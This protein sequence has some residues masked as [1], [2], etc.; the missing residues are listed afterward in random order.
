[1]MKKNE[2]SQSMRKTS[3]FLFNVSQHVKLGLNQ[4]NERKQTQIDNLPGLAVLIETNY[5]FVFVRFRL[6]NRS[7]L[8][9]MRVKLRV[10]F[11]Y[12]NLQVL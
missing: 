10:S 6:L 4:V 1:M 8:K 3:I 12:V 11:L 7:G 2:P 9:Y 5:S